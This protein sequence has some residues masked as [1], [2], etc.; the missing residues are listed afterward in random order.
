MIAR[1]R[2]GWERL[3]LYLPVLLMGL[4]ALGSWWLVR[5]APNPLPTLPER[6]PEHVSDYF[7]RDFSIKNFDATGQ[8]T[9]ELRGTLLRHYVDTDTL[10]IDQPRIR[11]ITPQGRV[12]TARAQRAVS[13]ADG[14]EVQLFGDAVVVRQPLTQPGKA[15]LPKLE[16]RSDFLHTWVNDERVRSNQPVTLMR[17]NDQFTADGMDYDNL[18]QVLNLRGRV[19]GTLQPAPVRR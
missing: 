2:Q 15:P 18:N 12:T 4:L 9:S 13:N 17:G 19:H 11:S 7:M 6:P 16:F 10:E 3:T 14:S 5:N 8:L 1:L